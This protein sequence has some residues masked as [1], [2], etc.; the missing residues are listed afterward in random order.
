MTEVRRDPEPE[1]DPLDDDNAGVPPDAFPALVLGR[2]TPRSWSVRY[3]DVGYVR[4]RALMAALFP[5][6][7]VDLVA[8]D[9][10]EPGP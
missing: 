10:T 6:L 4:D 1:L 8:P 2:F 5:Q 9:L 3:D 7:H